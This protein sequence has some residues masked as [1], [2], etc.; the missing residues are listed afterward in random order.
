M[1]NSGSRGIGGEGQAGCVVPPA[2]TSVSLSIEEANDLLSMLCNEMAQVQAILS[3]PDGPSSVLRGILRS[4]LEG[5]HWC[6]ASDR[7]TT[8]SALTFDLL[9]AIDR[10]FGDED[11]MSAAAAFPFRFRYEMALRFDFEN[12]SSLTLFELKDGQ[13]KGTGS[14]AI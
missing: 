2:D 13:E 10:R 6:V 5:R 8:G 9:A 7:D 14:E 3:F 1:F 11:S 4:P 12:G